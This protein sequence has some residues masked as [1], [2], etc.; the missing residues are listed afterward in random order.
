MPRLRLFGSFPNKCLSSISMSKFPN[1]KPIPLAFSEYVTADTKADTESPVFIIHGL[2]GS[3]TNW[4]TVS[5]QIAART[6]RK[7]VAVDLRN[8]GDSPHTQ[9]FSY[10]HMIAD[11]KQLMSEQGIKEGRATIMGHS[12]GGRVAMALAL[13]NPNSIR[14]LVIVDVSPLGF[15]PG[16]N[17]VPRLLKTLEEIKL[18]PGLTLTEARKDA[19]EQMKK[20]IRGEKLRNFLGTNLIL[21]EK[22]NKFAWKINVQSL[23][24]NFSSLM[25]FPKFDNVFTRPC[26]FIAG[27]KSGYLKKE[28]EGAIKHLFPNAGFEYVVGVGHLI[29]AEKPDL[30]L[31]I[32]TTF[33][34]K[35]I[36]IK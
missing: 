27:E 13:E 20:Y 5:K 22:S 12:I 8:H 25:T 36:S 6:H 24:E 21:D 9:E 4:N 18:K 11:L 3:R 14:D 2:F 30:F 33:L 17:F 32:V 1:A 26:L 23:K 15:P 16:V 35:N 34:K 28:D 29:H 7:V 31:D 10:N 19:K